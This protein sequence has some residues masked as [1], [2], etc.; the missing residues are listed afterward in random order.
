MATHIGGRWKTWTIAMSQVTGSSWWIPWPTGGE[1][2]GFA[3]ARP[4]GPNSPHR[5]RARAA[6]LLAAPRSPAARLAR[7]VPRTLGLLELGVAPGD[8][9]LA[10]RGLVL[11]DH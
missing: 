4:S 2:A 9:G 8:G 1:Y 3:R 7:S 6:A 11:V 5:R 10:V